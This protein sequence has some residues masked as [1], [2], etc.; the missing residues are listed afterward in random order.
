M[1]VAEQGRPLGDGCAA[2]AS[3]PLCGFA[4]SRHENGK[5]KPPLSL[6]KLV[7]VLDRQPNLLDEVR[8]GR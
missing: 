4:S 6:V 5:T 2:N 3:G 7:I 8:A 1:P